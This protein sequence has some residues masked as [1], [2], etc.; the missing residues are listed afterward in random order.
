MGSSHI[1]YIIAD[2]FLI[3][4]E[5]RRLYSEQVVYMPHT[6]QANDFRREISERIFTRAETGLPEDGFVFC[7][8]NNNYKITPEIFDVWMRLLGKVPDS[9][10]WLLQD[11]E[12]AAANLRREAAARGI[13]PER[14]IF[15][16]RISPA[17]HLA[18]QG[19]ADLFL[20]T[21]P[22]SAHTTCSDALFV[23][24]PVV[25]FYGPTF[26][27]RVAVSLLNAIGMSELAADS[28]GSYEARALFLAQ[29]REELK[30]VRAKLLRNRTSA[31][32]FDTARFTRDLERAYREMMTLQR[33]GL[34][35]RSFAVEQIP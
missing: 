34:A 33:K 19:L 30:A 25:S 7:C 8:F 10:L 17:E 6:Y 3:P 1:D 16:P 24:L 20:D 13:A 14:L 9:V 15:A 32:L 28:I 26:P 5:E 31:P 35:P 21:S 11:N 2:R 27:A 29:N 12:D 18:R 22:Y 4:A 23:G